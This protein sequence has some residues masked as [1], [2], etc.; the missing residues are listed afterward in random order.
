MPKLLGLDWPWNTEIIERNTDLK[1][2]EIFQKHKQNQTK[3]HFFPIRANLFPN[4][5][6]N[7]FIHGSSR[8]PGEI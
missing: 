1:L 2:L 7:E 5:T 4:K 8:D 6:D 3:S